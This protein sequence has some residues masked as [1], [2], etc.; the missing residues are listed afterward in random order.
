MAKDKEKDKEK[1]K[2]PYERYEEEAKG[3]RLG[4][5]PEAPDRPDRPQED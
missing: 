3:L 5:P 4:P 2:G 1:E